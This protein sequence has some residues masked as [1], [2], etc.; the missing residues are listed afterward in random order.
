MRLLRTSDTGAGGHKCHALGNSFA[1]LTVPMLSF[2]IPEQIDI[3]QCGHHETL[4][5]TLGGMHRQEIM[6]I[7]DT[8]YGLPVHQQMHPQ[9]R[10]GSVSFLHAL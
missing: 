3:G 8:R 6:S 4:L 9:R 7:R 10:L 1:L 2:N 5:K